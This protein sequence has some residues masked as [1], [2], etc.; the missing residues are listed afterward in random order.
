MNSVCVVIPTLNEAHTL[1]RLLGDLRLQRGVD[2]DVIV[3]D[4]GS[5]DETPAIAARQARLVQ[6]ERANRALQ[7]NLGAAEAH[8]EWLVFLHA[9]TRLPSP[10]VLEDAIATLA[11]LPENTA[12]HFALTFEGAG[13]DHVGFRYL[14]AKTRESRPFTTHGDQGFV[15][16]RGW[17]EALGGFDASLGFLEDQRFAE[18]LRRVGSW[19]TLPGV[20]V[21]SSRRFDTEGFGRRY[22]AMAMMMG[23]HH[24]GALDFFDRVRAYEPNPDGELDLGPFLAAA[25]DM[26]VFRGVDGAA[27]LWFEVGRYVRM[28]AWQLALM[29][30]VYVLG[31]PEQP[32]LRAFDATGE[33]LL[34]RPGVDALLGIGAATLF[35]VA[36]P[37]VWAAKE[38]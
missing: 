10:D 11:A 14:S 23:A 37:A 20:V 31:A 1:P 6:C 26:T 13:A 2:L 21:T 7:L 24:A 27:D 22:L 16:R 17:F 4:G 33:R 29:A 19:V 36:L 34:N 35:L 25:R 9:D 30:D 15:M 18:R 32:T 28:N 3:A 12:G 38:R 8:A 5:T